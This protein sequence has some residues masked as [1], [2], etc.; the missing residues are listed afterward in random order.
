[1][2]IRELFEM[3]RDLDNYIMKKNDLKIDKNTLM[4]SRM[5]AML[6]EVEEAREEIGGDREKYIEE[7]ADVL[8]FWLSLVN[9]MELELD[10]SYLHHVL[11]HDK[12]DNPILIDIFIYEA[13]ETILELIALTEVFKYWKTKKNNVPVATLE[14][15]M[16]RIFLLAFAANDIPEDVLIEAYIRK[17]KINYDRQNNGY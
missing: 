1:M 14:T 9:L 13:K 2:E 15:L 6:T 11:K 5:I 12:E 3:Q 4:L 8:H 16:T 10:M 7:T 17:N